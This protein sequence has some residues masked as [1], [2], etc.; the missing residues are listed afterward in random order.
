[1]VNHE[2]HKKHESGARGNE[3]VLHFVSFVYFVVK[4]VRSKARSDREVGGG[5]GRGAFEEAADE[6]VELFAFEEEGVVAE[7]G[8]K[9]GVTGA[10]A[11]AEEGLGDLAVLLGWEKPIAGEADDQRL[12]EHG[13]E[14]LLEGAVGVV[15]VELVEGARD[16]E[17]RVGV[18]AVDER[19]ALVPQVAL[20][21]ELE[22]EV[23][24]SG[25]G[26]SV[27]G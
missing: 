16:V 4:N 7:V 18:E 20:D 3:V 14:G 23:R 13:R 11:G 24:R 10:F 2:T 8:G 15:E 5:G 9:F 21:F 26:L 6:G 19:L 27:E 22:V 12:G 17:I 25:R 1:M